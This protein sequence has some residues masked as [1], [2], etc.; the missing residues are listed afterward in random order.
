[1]VKTTSKKI[2]VKASAAKPTCKP[3]PGYTTSGIK[4]TTRLY[5]IEDC[6]KTK[7]AEESEIL[8]IHDSS[9]TVSKQNLVKSKFPYIDTFDQKETAVVSTIRD[10]TSSVFDHSDITSPMDVDQILAYMQRILIG[11]AINKYKVV[12]LDCKQQ[13]ISQEK[14][15]PSAI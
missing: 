14:S 9:L 2:Y 15:G 3:P 1:M 11:D 5:A 8:I 12:M 10:L 7:E 6:D 13:R 4:P